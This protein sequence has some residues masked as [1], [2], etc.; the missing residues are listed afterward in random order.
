MGIAQ[1]PADI[2]AY[3]FLTAR[4]SHHRRE[5]SGIFTHFSTLCERRSL[6][7]C[8][9]HGQQQWKLESPHPQPRY[10]LGN[11]YYGLSFNGI[12]VY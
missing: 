1:P 9:S 2:A 8:T 7:D 4:L 10:A 3:E 5:L 12:P 11:P 6:L